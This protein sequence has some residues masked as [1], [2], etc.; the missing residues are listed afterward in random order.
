[1]IIEHKGVLSSTAAET[2][3]LIIT[4]AIIE[5]S[6]AKTGRTVDQ[7]EDAIKRSARHISEVN[8]LLARYKWKGD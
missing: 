2:Y 1:M 7:I 6:I 5:L 4:R 3:K 8:D